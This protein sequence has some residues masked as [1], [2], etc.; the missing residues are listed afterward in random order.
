M[1]AQFVVK[2]KDSLQ[3]LNLSISQARYDGA[4]A[5]SRAKSGVAKTITQLEK[6]AVYL[7]CYGH[8][9]NLACVDTIKN[10]KMWPDLH[11]YIF[12]K[13]YIRLCTNST[14]IQLTF[15]QVWR[16]SPAPFSR[17]EAF[18]ARMLELVNWRKGF[19][20]F[21]S[22]HVGDITINYVIG[23]QRSPSVPKSGANFDM[24]YAWLMCMTVSWQ[25]SLGICSKESKYDQQSWD[26]EKDMALPPCGMYC[27]AHI[28]Y[29][30]YPEFAIAKSKRQERLLEKKVWSNSGI[31]WR[32]KRQW[33][34][35]PPTMYHSQQR[36]HTM[37][38]ILP[39][40][41]PKG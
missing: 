23:Y 13:I 41:G 29:I 8:A 34:P 39:Y 32:A 22:I 28:I 24:W 4:S 12:A 16:R 11:I 1:L 20:M 40:H 15:L 26:G 2:I 27:E 17:Y 10:S 9:L 19:T 14:T 36:K 35:R 25:R 30:L 5:M 37:V 33:K 18:C 31:I 3:Q 38:R 7:H 21:T 6:Q